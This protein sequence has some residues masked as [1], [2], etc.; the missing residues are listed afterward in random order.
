MKIFSLFSLFL[1]FV[2]CTQQQNNSEVILA[3]TPERTLD[4]DGEKLPIQELIPMDIL[5]A[6]DEEDYIRKYNVKDF[7]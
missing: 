5:Y 7:L 2:A 1:F 6:T 3:A 4:L